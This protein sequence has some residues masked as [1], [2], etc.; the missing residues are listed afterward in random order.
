MNQSDARHYARLRYRLLVADLVASL[1]VLAA[2]QGSGVSHHLA[3]WASGVWTSEP[4]VIGGYLI[5]FGVLDYVALLPLY[6]YG[7]FVLEHRFGLSRLRMSGW[8][9]REL[10]HVLLGGALGLLL[11]EGWYAILRLAP[12]TWPIWA[13]V[14]W[15]GFSV[16]LAR[17][18]PTWLVPLFYKTRPLDDEALARRLLT[19]CEQTG[20]PALGVFRVGL[21]AETRKAN[22][23]LA[24]WGR[25]RRVLVSDTLLEGFSPDEIETVLAHELGHHRYRH[26]TKLLVISGVGSWL[27]FWL[28]KA[29]SGLWIAPLG[30]R[31]VA[32]VAGFPTLML[33]LSLIGLVGLPIQ[34]AI[35]RHF[36]WQ[37]DRFAVKTAPHPQAFAAALRKLAD[38]NL[39]DPSPPR[40]A[41]W[42][43]YDHPPITKR[44]H[45][46]AAATG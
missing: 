14:G 36:E 13:T 17:V 24:G 31:G 16:V 34:H 28:L 41:E 9:I 19:L 45:A 26:I 2:L 6:F 12:A 8:L 42:L 21:G 11:V 23:A 3:R 29:L 15:V 32:D 5:A 7:S 44:I 27:A 20:L 1:G 37:A 43:F 18:F 40:W 38:L 10:K 30:L 22:A 4:L 46:A 25:T 35:S 33:A 39:A